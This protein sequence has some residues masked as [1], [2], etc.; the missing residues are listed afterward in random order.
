M[1]KYNDIKKEL[2]GIELCIV[3][4]NRSKDQILDYYNKGERIFGENKAQ[5]LLTKVDLPKD[6]KWQFIGHLQ[7]NKVRSIM[8][9]VNCMQSVDSLELLKL[10][11]KEAARI[12]KV[13]DVMMQFNLAKEDSK[14]GMDTDDALIF[15]ENSKD[16]NNI[17][18]IGIM[19]MGPHTDDKE[20]IKVV[21]K[22]G[23]ELF[24]SLHNKY[25]NIKTL[26][27]GMSDDYKI[28]IEEKTTMV[29]IGS[30]LF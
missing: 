3:S 24:E 19:L 28:A 1:S 14:S 13:V 25:N 20:K 7:K 15:I 4:K 29:R 2:Q 21:F 16:L 27:M 8:P 9:Y 6:I 30:I 22:Q 26:S 23:R 10:I 17:N 18:I 12:N 5:E 11:N